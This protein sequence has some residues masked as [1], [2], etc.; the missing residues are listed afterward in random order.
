MATWTLVITFA[1]AGTYTFGVMPSIDPPV[2]R[3][4]YNTAEPPIVIG[5]RETWT[6]QNIYFITAGGDVATM[7]D[8][9]INNLWDNLFVATDQAVKFE[10]KLDGSVKFA[11]GTTTHDEFKVEEISAPM[12]RS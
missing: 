11:M 2:R 8:S 10:A 7:I 5:L 4:V 12:D 3:A 9:Y 6:I 1:G